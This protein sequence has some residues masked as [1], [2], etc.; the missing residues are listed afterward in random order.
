MTGR[1]ED[2]EVEKRIHTGKKKKKMFSST[3]AVVLSP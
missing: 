1:A 3:N 2:K